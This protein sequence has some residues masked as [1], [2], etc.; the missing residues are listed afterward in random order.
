M[1]VC[2]LIAALIYWDGTSLVKPDPLKILH[3][4]AFTAVEDF[5]AEAQKQK[6]D[7]GVH[8]QFGKRPLQRGIAA[9]DSAL[10]SLFS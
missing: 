6:V 5:S 1:C 2:V 3:N 10:L 7:V 9:G 8:G 4:Q